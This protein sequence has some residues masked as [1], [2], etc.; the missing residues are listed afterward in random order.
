MPR[1]HAAEGAR[2]AQRARAGRLPPDRRRPLER[3]DR[4]GALHQRDDG[5]DARHAHPPE[6]RPPRPRPRGRPGLPYRAGRSAA[7]RPRPTPALPASPATPA[8]AAAR[9]APQPRTRAPPKAGRSERLPGASGARGVAPICQ[10]QR[11]KLRPREAFAKFPV[12]KRV[13][14]PAAIRLRQPECTLDQAPSS[15]TSTGSRSVGAPSSPARRTRAAAQQPRAVGGPPGG[16]GRRQ[17]VGS[18]ACS[19]ARGPAAASPTPSR[20]PPST[21]PGARRP[22]DRGLPD[23]R[24]ARREDH[25]G[26]DPRRQPQHLR[27]GRWPRSAIRRW[28]LSC[29]DLEAARSYWH[30][31]TST[32][33][34]PASQ[35]RERRFAMIATLRRRRRIGWYEQRCRSRRRAGLVMEHA[36]REE[37]LHFAT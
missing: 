7:G 3:G 24:E 19:S 28:R 35:P 25:L 27:G 18:D 4:P 33:S 22:R 14:P 17:R 13:P 6:K 26:R 5:Q 15:P 10:C 16:Q 37:F 20:R 8:T 21:S 31:P 36:Q 2:R 34:R 23:P 12:E 1:R 32:T 30:G 29:V 11:Y 9:P